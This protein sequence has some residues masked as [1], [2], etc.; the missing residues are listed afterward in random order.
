M[1]QVQR[2]F[3]EQVQRPE[4]LLGP[5]GVAF[6]I[7]VHPLKSQA[8]V[9][10]YPGYQHDIDGYQGRY[11]QIADFIS[12]RERIGAVVRAANHTHPRLDYSQ[13]IVKDLRAVLKYT[14]ANSERICGAAKPEIY[15]MGFSAGASAAAA[16][17][18]DFPQIKKTL[19]IVPSRDAPNALVEAGLK[20]YR[21]ELY[22]AIAAADERVGVSVGIDFFNMADKACVR[23]S[24]VI[25]NCDHE[26]SG[27]TN[28]RILSS[29]PVWAFAGRIKEPAPEHGIK[30]Y[31]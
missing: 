16:V 12:D 28:G 9:V 30:L 10:N 27:E 1:L 21:G 26:F 25:S 2:C 20:S 13:S 18:S 19:L 3:Q 22:I 6:P 24:A 23:E 31:D 5:Q 15:L 29:L 14:L 8:I 7:I 11:Q 17:L 4:G